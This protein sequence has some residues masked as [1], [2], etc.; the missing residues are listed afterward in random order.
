MKNIV[1]KI[2][3]QLRHF[4]WN[5][6]KYNTHIE[7]LYMISM[8]EGFQDTLHCIPL[9]H[10]QWLCRDLVYCLVHILVSPHCGQKVIIVLKRT[11]PFKC[12]TIQTEAETK[13]SC[14]KENTRRLYLY[15]TL[16]YSTVRSLYTQINLVFCYT[17]D[18]HSLGSVQSRGKQTRVWCKG[19]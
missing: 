13:A 12:D 18:W 11:D 9:T 15:I 4:Y 8:N 2:S 19:P 6:V 7:T 14:M 16:Q 1:C 3:V 5:N 17:H 10:L